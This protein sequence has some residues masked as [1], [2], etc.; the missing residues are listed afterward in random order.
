M[1]THTDTLI[2]MLILRVQFITYAEPYQTTF[3][4]EQTFLLTNLIIIIKTTGSNAFKRKKKHNL[5]P[6][7]TR[8]PYSKFIQIQLIEKF[9]Q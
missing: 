2:N 3:K 7:T 4:H 1:Y 5:H 9:I 6:P 8:K